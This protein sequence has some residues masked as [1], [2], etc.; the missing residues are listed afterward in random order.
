MSAGRRARSPL[1]FEYRDEKA[2]CRPC[3]HT[4]EPGSLMVNACCGGAPQVTAPFATSFIDKDCPVNKLMLRLAFGNSTFT[5]K[6]NQDPVIA[7]L[8][9]ARPSGVEQ[10]A[11]Q[12]WKIIR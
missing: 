2:D 10:A 5:S 1:R 9:G 4:L 8:L 11:P 6:R 3:V 7:V 12:T